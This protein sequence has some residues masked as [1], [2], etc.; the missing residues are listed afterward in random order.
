MAQ[1]IG[2]RGVCAGMLMLAAAL[3]SSGVSARSLSDLDAVDQAAYQRTLVMRVARAHIQLAASPGDQARKTLQDS[4]DQVDRGLAQLEENSPNSGINQRIMKMKQLWQAYRTQALDKPDRSSVLAMLEQ[5]N[6]LLFQSDALVRDWQAR[7]PQHVGERSELAQQ[8][9]ML[10]ERMGVYFAAYQYGIHESWVQE[11]MRYSMRAFDDG[12][13]EL[14]D[15]ARDYGDSPVLTQLDAQWKSV[16]GGLQTGAVASS[17]TLAAV[18]SLFQHS[19]ELGALYR[20]DDRMVM[21]HG[22]SRGLDIGL[23]SNLPLD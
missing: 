20:E 22:Y 23:A 17:S 16:R 10:S 19:G 2:L 9:G 8:Q 6:N 18:E 5:S 3:G 14:R 12:L 4:I 15:A 13:N 1:S 11:E 21:R 7:L